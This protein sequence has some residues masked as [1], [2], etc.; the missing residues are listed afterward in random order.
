MTS[1]TGPSFNKKSNLLYH[2]LSVLGREYKVI[3]VYTRA[4]VK[5]LLGCF[6]FC[7]S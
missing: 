2:S 1:S 4:N 3:S 6:K 5:N 7:S